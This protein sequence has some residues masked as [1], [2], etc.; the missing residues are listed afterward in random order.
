MPATVDP[1]P[2]CD[3]RAMANECVQMTRGGDL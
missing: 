3:A 2:V 1:F